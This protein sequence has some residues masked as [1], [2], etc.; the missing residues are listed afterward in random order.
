MPLSRFVKNP[1]LGKK[2]HDHFGHFFD[3][4]FFYSY[5][6]HESYEHFLDIFSDLFFEQSIHH[7]LVDETDN[8]YDL[9]EGDL[10]V[11]QAVVLGDL[12]GEVVGDEVQATN[13][14]KFVAIFVY[15]S[16][17]HYFLPL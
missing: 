14:F 4:L 11:D 12:V 9:D 13:F 16:M 2:N 7:N 1:L 6:Y 3:L 10:A 5:D 15:F 17:V 8:E